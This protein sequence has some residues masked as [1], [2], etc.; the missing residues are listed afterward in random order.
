MYPLQQHCALQLPC[1]PQ[2]TAAK[3]LQQQQQHLRAWVIP[4]TV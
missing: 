1:Q 2:R 3:H 4:Y